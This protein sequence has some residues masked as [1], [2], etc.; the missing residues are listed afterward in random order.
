MNMF[1]VFV[2]AAVAL[3]ACVYAGSASVEP[4]TVVS[5]RA[6]GTV[7]P[8]ELPCGYYI[9]AE[10]YIRGADDTNR[11]EYIGVNQNYMMYREDRPNKGY[12]LYVVR[13]DGDIITE[14]DSESGSCRSYNASQAAFDAFVNQYLGP[15]VNTMECDTLYN[16]VVEGEN[17]TICEIHRS[18]YYT[19]NYTYNSEGYCVYISWDYEYEY[20]EYGW[21][22]FTYTLEPPAAEVFVMHEGYCDPIAYTVPSEEYLCPASGPST[23]PETNDAEWEVHIEF[24]GLDLDV[25]ALNTEEVLSI[26]HDMSGIDVN[27]MRIEAQTDS[28]GKVI[29]ITVYLS[30]E[31]SANNLMG[32]V[33]RC[34]T[35][36]S[37]SPCDGIMQ[38]VRS[39]YVIK[40]DPLVIAD[41]GNRSNGMKAITTILFM[42]TVILSFF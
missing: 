30:E 20:G 1:K 9:N 4:V 35:P 41:E 27:E 42:L 19:Y 14:H 3:A 22:R 7:I 33:N 5:K 31:V 15:L 40:S 39:V 6:G 2:I 25:S 32:V 11:M 37:R 16:V 23:N 36:S 21:R 10:K 17:R 34:L 18:D 12:Y 29:G 24:E 8:H 28:T 13:K 38:Y 26:L